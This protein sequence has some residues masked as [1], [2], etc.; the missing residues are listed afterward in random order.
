MTRSRKTERKGM[1]EWKV[2][3]WEEVPEVE[4]SKMV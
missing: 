2:V 3:E 4:E 1:A